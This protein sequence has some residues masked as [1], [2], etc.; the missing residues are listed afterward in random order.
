MAVGYMACTASICDMQVAG[1]ILATHDG[2]SVQL[3]DCELEANIA[4]ATVCAPEFA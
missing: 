2:T 1:A 3:N 4:N